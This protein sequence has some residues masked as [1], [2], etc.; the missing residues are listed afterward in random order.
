VSEPDISTLAR[1]LAEQN[2][3]DWRSLKGSGPSGKVVE[4]DVLDYLARVM[5]GE[6]SLDPTP[7]P[8]PEGMQAWPDQDLRSFQQGLGESASSIQEVR[9]HLASAAH[10]A[11]AESDADEAAFPDPGAEAEFGASEHAADAVS[12][13]GELDDDLQFEQ[14]VAG[15]RMA[16]LAAGAAA[17]ADGAPIGEDI[18]LFDD[19]DAHDAA[20]ADGDRG[21]EPLFGE[22]TE[23]AFGA[24]QDEAVSFGVD[25]GEPTAGDGWDGGGATTAFVPAA[26]SG[27][28]DDSDELLLVDGDDEDAIDGASGFDVGSL[29]DDASVGAGHRP[30][31]AAGEREAPAWAGE[32]LRIGHD[33]F[34]LDDEADDRSADDLWVAGAADDAEP[35][36]RSGDGAS[37]AAHEA[38]TGDDLWDR[39]DDDGPAGDAWADVTWN[40]ADEAAG[41]TGGPVPSF[42]EPSMV[43][44]QASAAEDAAPQ[45]D[46][47]AAVTPGWVDEDLEA[48]VHAVEEAAAVAAALAAGG[49]ARLSASA[50]PL[51]RTTPLLRRHIDVSALAAAQ[52]A[53]GQELG[54]DEPL[55]AAA[56][57]LRAVAKAAR[58]VDF[59]GG[60]V[61]LAVLDDAVRLVRVDDAATRSFGSLVTEVRRAVVEE[62]EAGLVAA[63]LSGLDLDEV[64]LDVGAPVVTLGRILYDNQ[65]GAYRSTLSLAGE[66]PLDQGARLLA[67]VADLLD[68]PV[69]LVL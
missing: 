34:G 43:E 64:V 59:G 68:A 7:E 21:A 57:L 28:S 51:A 10:G 19:E 45:Q 30:D 66:L 8:L 61:A 29:G 17:A 1:R 55:G 2:N 31:A 5:A 11:F 36:V 6:E 25:A 23:T 42:D 53:V 60:Q 65:R 48:P 69:R 62:D 56:F 22:G 35:E 9:S 47:A 12:A 38:G 24:G 54:D 58:E 40:G 67:R 33:A 27:A 41:G 46:E 4:R 32:E 52:L 20:P 26:S 44:A 39:R 18:F 49:E 16:G 63:D 37:G 3:V 13:L 14:D 50:L 15:V